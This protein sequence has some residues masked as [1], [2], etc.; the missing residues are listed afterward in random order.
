MILFWLILS[1]FS[2]SY[3]VCAVESKQLTHLDFC[4]SIILCLLKSPIKTGLQTGRSR[5]PASPENAKCDGADHIRVSA[6]QGR[7][8]I[9]QNN[10]RYICRKCNIRNV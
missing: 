9:C 8:K 7:C 2:R 10:T 6:P 4:R 5:I 3:P 1:I